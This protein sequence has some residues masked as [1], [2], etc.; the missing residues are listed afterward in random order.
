MLK[1]AQESATDAA[2]VVAEAITLAKDREK[3]LAKAVQQADAVIVD[4]AKGVSNLKANKRKVVSVI[5]QLS[6]VRWFFSSNFTLL[7]QRH[8]IAPIIIIVFTSSGNYCSTIIIVAIIA[9]QCKLSFV[10]ASRRFS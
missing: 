5:M 6:L 4:E 8:F 9:I 10:T 7:R 2:G 1:V 3:E